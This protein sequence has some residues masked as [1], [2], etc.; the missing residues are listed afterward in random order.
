MAQED[1][2]QIEKNLES[3]SLMFTKAFKPIFECITD[4]IDSNSQ[5]EV[6]KGFKN[7]N[8]SSTHS[9]QSASNNLLLNL[10]SNL[11]QVTM[12]NRLSSPRELVSRS[13]SRNDSIIVDDKNTSS[14]RMDNS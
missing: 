4:K 14:S 12:N 2:S 7:I 5:P 9:P 11:H 1:E 3:D 13:L 8:R 10:S 6:T